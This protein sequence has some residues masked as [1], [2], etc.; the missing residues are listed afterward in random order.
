MENRVSIEKSPVLHLE[1]EA[2]ETEDEVEN[3]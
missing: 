3:D 1:I 2:L